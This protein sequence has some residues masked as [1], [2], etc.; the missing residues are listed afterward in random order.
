MTNV[1]TSSKRHPN[2]K[3]RRSL[4]HQQQKIAAT[5]FLATKDPPTEGAIGVGVDG[6][7]KIDPPGILTT[8]LSCILL[9]EVLP[10]STIATT[11]ATYNKR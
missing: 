6:G 5:V 10:Q 9:E 4:L 8:T 2:H 1:T 11:K 3:D 7:K